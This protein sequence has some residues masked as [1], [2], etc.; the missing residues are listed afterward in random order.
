M[1]DEKI[2]SELQN[3]TEDEAESAPKVQADSTYSV[4]C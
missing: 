3:L 1:S 4:I 2:V